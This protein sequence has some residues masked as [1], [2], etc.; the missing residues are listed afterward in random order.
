[1]RFEVPQ[2]IEIEDR[3]FGPLTW[4]QFVYLAGGAGFGVIIFFWLPF[5]FFIFLAI[6]VGALAAALAFY[7]INNRPFSIFLESVYTYFKNHRLYLWKRRSPFT[8]QKAP[9]NVPDYMLQGTGQRYAPPQNQ[10]R[11]ASLSR[12][13]ELN[14]LQKKE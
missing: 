8:P 12:Q 11:L 1:M 5:I 7:P 6:P 13:L 9:S 10:D 2:F 3:I 4:K 14:A